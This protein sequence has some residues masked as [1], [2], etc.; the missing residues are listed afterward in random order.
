MVFV[1]SFSSCLD[2][3]A[4]SMDMG[5]ALDTNNE[6]MTVGISNF[7]SGLAGGQ[8]GSYIFSQT[9][10]TY[11]T[12]CNSRWIGVFVALI[13]LAVVISTVN[14]LEVTPVST[15]FASYKY[16]ANSSNTTVWLLL[17]SPLQL[18]FLG[19]TLL[20]IGFDLMFEWLVEVRHKVS[21]I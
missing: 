7:I 11:R 9:I 18:F 14:F 2:V 3:A 10:F 6:L 15:F 13:F 17:S 16:A 20:F 1:V 19:S 4:I 8:T 5:E 12:G 21:E